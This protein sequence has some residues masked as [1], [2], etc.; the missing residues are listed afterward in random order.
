MPASIAGLFNAVICGILCNSN[1]MLSIGAILITCLVTMT[2]Y[3]IKMG[4]TDF[5]AFAI[6]GNALFFV[7]IALYTTEKREKTELLQFE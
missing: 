1:W 2:Y 7:F 3:S 5:V 4:Y 6:V